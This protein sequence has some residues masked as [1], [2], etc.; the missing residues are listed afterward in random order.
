MTTTDTTEKGLESLIV[1]TMAG[2]LVRGSVDGSLGE[3]VALYGGTGWILVHWQ[4]YNR[5]YAVDLVQL[6][7]FLDATQ[8]AVAAAVDLAH[9]SPTRRKFLARL[10]GEISKRG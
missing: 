3:P 2:A 4:D 6:Q 7:A 5:E 8:P 10:Q 1:S 9:D